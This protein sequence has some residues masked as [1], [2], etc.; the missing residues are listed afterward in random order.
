[1]SR[2]DLLSDYVRVKDPHDLDR[3]NGI[4][5]RGISLRYG[6]RIDIHYQ[7]AEV[8]SGGSHFWTQCIR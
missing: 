7:A 6:H 1:M 3:Q 5:L 2:S 4:T 8:F